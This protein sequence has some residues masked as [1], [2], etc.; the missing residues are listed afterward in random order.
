MYKRRLVLELK[1]KTTFDH[2]NSHRSEK[3]GNCSFRLLVMTPI[4]N[5]VIA[6]PWIQL[7]ARIYIYW[8]VGLLFTRMHLCYL[9]DNV[10]LLIPSLQNPQQTRHDTFLTS[11]SLLYCEHRTLEGC[12]ACVQS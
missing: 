7:T 2:E 10:L 9:G 1:W 6:G 8:V 5:S 11:S 3:I 12:L 4:S